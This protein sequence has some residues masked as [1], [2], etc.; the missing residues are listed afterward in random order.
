MQDCAHD[1]A[2]DAAACEPQTHAFPQTQLG[3]IR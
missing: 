1:H 3:R 2:R